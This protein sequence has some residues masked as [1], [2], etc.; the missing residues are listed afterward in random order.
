MI[1]VK[2]I[3]LVEVDRDRVELAIYPPPS[4]RFHA[5]EI[6][7][8]RDICITREMIEGRVFRN[9]FGREICIGMRKEVQDALGLPFEAFEGLRSQVEQKNL[10]VNELLSRLENI[11]NMGFWDRFKGLIFSYKKIED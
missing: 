9:S 8:L 1:C 10:I 5:G 6:P 4:V 11:R 7:P 2:S 3:E